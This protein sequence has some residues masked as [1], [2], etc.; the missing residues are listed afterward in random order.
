[1]E[2]TLSSVPDREDVVAEIW[3]E[4][5][6]LAELREEGE[7]LV[8]EVYGRP[9]GVPWNLNYSELMAGLRRAKERLQTSNE[10]PTQT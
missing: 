3:Y 1:M 6:M 10:S 9:G 4:D 5:E 7:S 2:V 8:I